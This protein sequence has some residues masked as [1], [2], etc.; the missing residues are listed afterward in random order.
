V[1]LIIVTGVV[2]I[3]WRATQ[4]PLRAYATQ[5]AGELVVWHLRLHTN[6]WPRSWEDLAA[7][8]AVLEREYSQL[9]T[10]EGVVWRTWDIS[11]ASTMEE[12]RQFIEIDWSAN[13]NALR[14]TSVTN[15]VRPFRVV[16]LKKA[17]DTYWEGLEPNRMIWDYL[18]SARTNPPPL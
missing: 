8:H 15:E 1:C 18:Q 10:D 14:E 12:M 6:Q 16:R 13:V 7:T 3:V 9:H 4:V 11:I 2:L 17:K 5:A